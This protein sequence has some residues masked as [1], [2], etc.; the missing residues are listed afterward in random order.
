MFYFIFSDIHGNVEAL[1]RVVEEIEIARP[2]VVVSLGDV[3]G[4]G[5]NPAECIDIVQKIAHIR[6]G[7][8]HDLAAAGLTES[9]CFNPTAKKSIR[10]T[11]TSLDP[12]R[13]DILEEYDPLRRHGSCLFAHASPLSPLNWDY[14]YTVDQAKRI[15]DSFFEKYI[16][17]GHTHIPGIISYSEENG[18]RVV[19]GTVV[20]VQ[21]GTRYLVNVGSVG[22]PRDGMAA[23]SFVMLDTKKEWIMI[24]RVPYD[25]MSA[26]DKIRSVGLPESLALR[27]ATAR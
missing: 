25:I 22:Q 15:F 10:W 27:L 21:P 1:E 4:Y 5:A 2:D 8:N 18:I 3:V 16:F 23:A 13:R 24:R 19:T 20:Q 7:G 6:I 14:V 26:Q 11:V 12:S 9:D 17:I